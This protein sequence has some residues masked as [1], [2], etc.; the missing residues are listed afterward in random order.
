MARRSPAIPP[1]EVEDDLQDIFVLCCRGKRRRRRAAC[2][3]LRR[4]G[5]CFAQARAGVRGHDDLVSV[6][7]GEVNAVAGVTERLWIADVNAVLRPAEAPVGGHGKRGGELDEEGEKGEGG[8]E[9]EH[10][11]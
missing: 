6:L 7:T 5:S 4:S 9:E 8:K 10:N 11:R 2:A 3:S 1:L